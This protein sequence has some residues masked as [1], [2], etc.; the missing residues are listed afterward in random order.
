MRDAK[1][2]L[3]ASYACKPVRDFIQIDGF[4][5]MTG[6]MM[7]DEDGDCVCSIRVRDDLLGPREQGKR[8][9]LEPFARVREVELRNLDTPLR[10][11]IHRG[12]DREDVL[13]LLAKAYKWIAQR[14]D[15]LEEAAYRCSSC[16]R[17][18]WDSLWCVGCGQP[19]KEPRDIRNP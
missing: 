2:E 19:K 10:I 7:A 4:S 18:L 13:R 8:T 16:Q 15:L 14:D 11:Q 5:G 3:L 9:D 17:T 6:D 12:A 1:N